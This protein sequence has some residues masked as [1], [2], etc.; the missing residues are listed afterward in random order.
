MISKASTKFTEKSKKITAKLSFKQHLM[1]VTNHCETFQEGYCYILGHFSI[2]DIAYH[3]VPYCI[4][5]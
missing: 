1:G 4:I 3:V 5:C 2:T